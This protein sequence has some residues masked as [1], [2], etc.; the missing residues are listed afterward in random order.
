VTLL[1]I[2]SQIHL[3]PSRADTKGGGLGS[4]PG[5]QYVR[6]PEC[7]GTDCIEIEINLKQENT[8]RFMSCRRCEAKWWQRGGDPIELDEVLDLATVQ[9]EPK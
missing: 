7:S 4:K 6:C 3:K 1:S 9:R 2:I 5:R 8:V